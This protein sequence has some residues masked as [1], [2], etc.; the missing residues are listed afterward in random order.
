MLSIFFRHEHNLIRLYKNPDNYH[1]LPIILIQR[2]YQIGSSVGSLFGFPS[3][4][5][6]GFL[7]GASAVS[8]V[9]SLFGFPIAFPVGSPVAV[10]VG[11]PVGYLLH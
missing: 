5:I 6:V 9:V 8:L 4:S 2:S 11:Y 7:I 3:N 1:E 10:L